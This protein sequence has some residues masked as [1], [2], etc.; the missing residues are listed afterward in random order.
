MPI[1]RCH[2]VNDSDLTKRRE[3]EKLTNHFLKE[4]G[5]ASTYENK[6]HSD[7]YQLK[8]WQVNKA[9]VGNDNAVTVP[10][11]PP[12]DAVAHLSFGQ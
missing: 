1:K 7:W 4:F 2:H 5:K 8:M 3:S 10:V 12:A 11:A 9:L 6:D